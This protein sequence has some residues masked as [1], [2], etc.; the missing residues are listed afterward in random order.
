MDSQGIIQEGYVTE[1]DLLAIHRGAPLEPWENH[2]KTPENHGKIMGK[3]WEE[4]DFEY[5]DHERWYG[6]YGGELGL[7]YMKYKTL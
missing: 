7:Q 6:D 4:G 3:P 2:G 1:G 5:F